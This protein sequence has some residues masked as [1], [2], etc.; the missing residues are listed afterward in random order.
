MPTTS[1]QQVF[2][3][4]CKKKETKEMLDEIKNLHVIKNS[5]FQ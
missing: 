3:G 1:L 5:R 4:F 2:V